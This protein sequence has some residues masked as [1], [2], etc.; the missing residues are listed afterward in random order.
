MISEQPVTLVI[1]DDHTLL[2]EGIKSLLKQT[3]PRIRVVGE[4][5]TGAEAIEV[6]QKL[7]PNVLMLDISMPDLSGLDALSVIAQKCPDTR[8]LM[9]SMHSDPFRI[10]ESMAK[11]AS[12]YILKD[13]V[14]ED[15]N[16]AIKTVLQGSVY[17]KADLAPALWSLQGSPSPEATG[18][19]LLTDRENEIARQL[20]AGYSSKQIASNLNVSLNTVRTHRAKIMKKLDAHSVVELIKKLG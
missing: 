13:A 9:L 10:R 15:L 5:G 2:R 6:C 16:D 1:A 8:V 11:G 19:P 17:L 4:A 14:G 20:K 3:N 7:K 18:H 12:G